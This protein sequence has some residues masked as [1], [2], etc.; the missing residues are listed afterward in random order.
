MRTREQTERYLDEHP[1]VVVLVAY[2]WT[3]GLML[4]LASRGVQA[5]SVDWRAPDHDLPSHQG[6]VREVIDLRRWRAVYSVGPACFQGIRHDR[7]LAAKIAD[8]RAFW[9]AAEVIWCICCPHA[10]ATL[11]EQPDTIVHDY[12]ELAA[13][14]SEP[15]GVEVL[16]LRSGALGD[17]HDK[18]LRLTMVGFDVE[19]PHEPMALLEVATS[20]AKSAPT[21]TRRPAMTEY[22]NPDAR[23]RARSSWK[24]MPALCAMVASLKLKEGPRVKL[25][26]ETE[27]RAFEEQWR[28]AGNPTPPHFD[29]PTGQPLDADG[30]NYQRRRGEGDGRRPGNAAATPTASNATARQARKAEAGDQ[31]A[32]S[33]VVTNFLLVVDRKVAEGHDLTPCQRA[34]LRELARGGADAHPRTLFFWRAEPSAGLPACFSNFFAVDFVDEAIGGGP[35]AH[36][37]QYMH[38]WKAVLAG[39]DVAAARVRHTPDPKE[40]RALGRRVQ[41][42]DDGAWCKVAR[43]IVL[44]GVYLKFDQ[45]AQLKDYLLSTGSAELAEASPTDSRWGVGLSERLARETARSRWG[46]NWL[47]VAVM[48][49]RPRL[50]RGLTPSIPHALLGPLSRY[51]GGGGGNAQHDATLSASMQALGERL[52]PDE[53]IV[54]RGGSGACGPNSVAYAAHVAQLTKAPRD[55][56]GTL[57]RSQVCDHAAALLEAECVWAPGTT[58]AELLATALSYVRR[59]T[60]T[61]LVEAVVAF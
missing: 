18:F 16:E 61:G 12:L 20:Q 50:E 39:D 15:G 22:A 7:C 29:N 47:G 2:E 23:D 1:E 10:D 25:D 9:G 49:S 28:K 51:L 32:A 36:V 34:R 14:G 55:A 59:G 26:Y 24:L 30:L 48:D 38:F 19:P 45:N 13:M 57:F 17:E 8:C 3:G 41:G 27:I 11:T 46:T 56:D 42:F 43:W 6:D 52:R 33:D 58:A 53:K 21:P 31:V 4:A 54:D 40:C 60:W 37:E 35:F 5:M 44:R